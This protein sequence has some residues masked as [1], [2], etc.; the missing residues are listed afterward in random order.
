MTALD[1]TESRSTRAGYSSSGWSEAFLEPNAMTA[2]QPPKNNIATAITATSTHT[3]VL[4]LG[5]A[6][7]AVAVH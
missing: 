6:G 4:R 3:H 2:A 5:A 1:N 7:T